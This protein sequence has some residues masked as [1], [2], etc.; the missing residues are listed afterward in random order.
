LSAFASFP[1]KRRVEQPLNE[2]ILVV[3]YGSLL[4]GFGLLA[5]RRGGRSRLVARDGW[6]VVIENARRGLAKPSSHGRYLAMDLEPVNPCAP[7]TARVGNGDGHA[8]GPGGLLLEFDREW[9]GRIARREEYDAGAFARLLALADRARKPL[10]EF[11]L[12]VAEAVAFSLDAYRL[13]LRAM[14][15][16]TSAGYIFHPVALGDGRTAIVA[17]GSGYHSSGDPAVVS[18]R[19]EFGM[20]RMVTLGEA[21]ALRHLGLDRQ[22]QIGYF[23]E[24]LLGGLHGISIADLMAGFDP[25]ADWAAEL[26]DAFDRAAGGERERFLAA[27]AMDERRYAE[28]FAARSAPSIARLLKHRRVG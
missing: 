19:R 4:S 23:A 7:I 14:L 13:K 21:L 6:P 8:G 20:E 15:G 18:R 11:L 5:E 9:A 2:R 12:A 16:Y 3:G 1:G 28:R 27:V 17:I 26:A 22:G 24:C 10:G 25:A